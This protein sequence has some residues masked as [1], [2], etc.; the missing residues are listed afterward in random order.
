M[1]IFSSIYLSL[2][3]VEV[4]WVQLA[5][6]Q[7]SLSWQIANTDDVTYGL[8]LRMA[9][10]GGLLGYLNENKDQ[11]KYEVMSTW[12]VILSVLQDLNTIFKHSQNL[13][14]Q[15]VFFNAISNCL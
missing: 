11:D 14:L 12:C 8:Q 1:Y 5:G 10:F 7:L 6:T 2:I 13:A 15:N 4:L 9:P 3:Q